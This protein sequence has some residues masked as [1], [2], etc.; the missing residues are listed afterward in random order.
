MASGSGG[1][2]AGGRRRESLRQGEGEAEGPVDGSHLLE[3][4]GNHASGEPPF[5]DGRDGVEVRHAALRHPSWLLM[6]RLV[7]DVVASARGRERGRG[8]SVRPSGVAEGGENRVG[9]HRLGSEA[10]QR[11]AN[12]RRVARGPG[13]AQAHP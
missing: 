7:D 13:K 6:S 2:E 12:Q 1:G 9:G 4:Q 3:G 10:S 11:R 5:R 8:S